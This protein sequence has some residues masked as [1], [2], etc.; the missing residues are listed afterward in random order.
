M[1]QIKNPW[2]AYRKFIWVSSTVAKIVRSGRNPN[3]NRTTHEAHAPHH[4]FA[5]ERPHVDAPPTFH[6]DSGW[7][8]LKSARRARPRSRLRRCRSTAPRDASPWPLAAAS[9]HSTFFCAHVSAFHHGRDDRVPTLR[10]P[11][12]LRKTG[13]LPEL[14]CRTATLK[15]FYIYLFMGVR[16]SMCALLLCI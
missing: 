16:C 3:R 1:K 11:V 15:Q 14:R 9:G 2:W 10:A 13:E 5:R 7:H 12:T 8:R 6:G 4:F